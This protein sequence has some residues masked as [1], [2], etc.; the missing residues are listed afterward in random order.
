VG[1]GAKNTGG[2]VLF[3]DPGHTGGIDAAGPRPGEAD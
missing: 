2:F 3:R 1:S